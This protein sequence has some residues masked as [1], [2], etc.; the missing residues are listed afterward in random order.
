[1]NCSKEKTP[2]ALQRTRLSI[3]LALAKL[4]QI[5]QGSTRYRKSPNLSVSTTNLLIR[6]ALLHGGY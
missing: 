4:V 6:C 1:M 3:P 2:G 5:N